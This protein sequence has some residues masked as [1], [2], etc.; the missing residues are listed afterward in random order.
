[1]LVVPLEPFL[2]RKLHRLALSETK[3]DS[4]GYK[5]AP[6]AEIPEIETRLTCN[7]LPNSGSED[8]PY[9]QV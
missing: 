9:A 7:A 1:M 8:I 6:L 3:T 5:T 2:S 4:E